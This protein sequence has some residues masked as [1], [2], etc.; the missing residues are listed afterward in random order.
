MSEKAITSQREL[1]IWKHEHDVCL[2]REVLLVEPYV[3]KQQ[4]KERGQA[5]RTVTTNLNSLEQPV[6]KV[7]IRAVR[8]RFFKLLEKFKKNERE[9][10]RASGIQGIELDEVSMGL[11][12]INERIEE[13]KRMWSETNDKEKERENNEK[14]KALDMRRKATETLS[15]TKKRKEAEGGLL[16]SKRQRRSSEI[17]AVI[18]EGIKLKREM[19][20]RD[21]QLREQE[22]N[23]RRLERECQ[24]KMITENHNFMK[25]MLLAMQQQN[26]QFLGQI[27]ELFKNLKKK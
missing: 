18:E 8:D 12:D 27:T 6:F 22:L 20:E 11:A 2:I 9:E 23:E 19:A 26:M 24:Q 3:H 17:L 10:A 1:F 16:P 5:W 4:S 13:A 15:E 14:E 25:N 7:A 21:A